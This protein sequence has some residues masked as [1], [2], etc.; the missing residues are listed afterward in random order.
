M[1][2]LQACLDDVKGVQQQHSGRA[3]NAAS[4]HVLPALPLLLLQLGYCLLLLLLLLVCI[5][6]LLL[7]LPTG[8]AVAAARE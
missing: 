7:L 1:P 5:V 6:F 4:D 2:D 8:H 3:S